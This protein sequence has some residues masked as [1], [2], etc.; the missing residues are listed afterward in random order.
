MNIIVNSDTPQFQ[1][2]FAGQVKISHDDMKANFPTLPLATFRADFGTRYVKI[3]RDDSAHA[4]IDRTNGDVLKPASWK[5]PAKHARGNIF[6][7]DNGLSQMGPYGPA[8]L[9]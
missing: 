2:W 3:V 8:Y 5:A 7:P 9:R 1:S 6:N 4:F